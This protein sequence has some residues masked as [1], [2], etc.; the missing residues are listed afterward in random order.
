MPQYRCCYFLDHR[1]YVVD[2]RVIICE[3]DEAARALADDLLHDSVYPAIEVWE[4]QRQV[5]AA[6][7]ALR[8]A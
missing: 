3:T 7:K 2:H 1:L 8:G 5:H 6:R 4:G